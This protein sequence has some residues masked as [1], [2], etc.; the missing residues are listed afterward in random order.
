MKMLKNKIL[1]YLFFVVIIIS[2]CTEEINLELDS[3]YTRL[4]V[5]GKITTDTTVHTI[6][7]SKSTDAVGKN[8]IEYISNA[9]V[10]VSDGDSTIILHENP[11]KKGYYETDSNYYA[12]VGKTYT[13][14]ITNVDINNDGISET[15]TASSLTKEFFRLDSVKIFPFQQNSK[16]HSGK[17]ISVFGQDPGGKNYYMFNVFK[18][19]NLS[20]REYIIGDNSGAEGQYINNAPIDL[21]FDKNPERIM[22]SDTIKVE[23]CNITKEYYDYINGCINE[24]K[25]NPI[26]SGPSSNVITNIQPSDKA[27]GFFST[28]SVSRKNVIFL[29]K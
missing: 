4:V 21:V 25:K 20:I 28:Y 22:N 29:S 15:F 9:H 3:T 14:T 6:I 16:Q 11:N 2:G 17:I 12:I 5:E 13:L 19:N 24:Y 10:T 23:A 18:N 27:V 8:P 7:L 26:F 1:S